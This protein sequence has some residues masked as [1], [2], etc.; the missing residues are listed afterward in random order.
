LAE[1]KHAVETE[2]QRV[3]SPPPAEDI[4]AELLPLTHHEVVKWQLRKYEFANKGYQAVGYGKLGAPVR[5][6]LQ[7]MPNWST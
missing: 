7:V 2:M 6:A 1:S 3:M 4:V 5:E